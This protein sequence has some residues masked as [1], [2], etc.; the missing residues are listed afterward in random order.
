[1]S[2]AWQIDTRRVAE[3]GERIERQLTAAQLPRLRKEC[4]SRFEPVQVSLQGLFTPYGKPGVRVALQ[5]DLRVPCQR[6]L[7]PLPVAL[8]LTCA[9]EWVATESELELRDEDDEWDAVLAAEQ[10]DLLPLLEDELL[11]ALPFAPAH[12]VCKPAA[13][14]EAGEKVSPFAALAG[15]KALK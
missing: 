11:L 6:C 5:A 2:D 7:K 8:A 15:L 1:M 14:F 3:R 13:E 12:A 10:I 9:F 4:V